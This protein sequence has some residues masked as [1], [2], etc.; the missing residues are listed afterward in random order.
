MTTKDVGKF[1]R[2]KLK[3]NP[4]LATQVSVEF[5]LAILAQQVY[6]LRIAAKLTQKELAQRIGVHRS[7]ISKIEDSD[8]D[9][10]VRLSTFMT[11]MVKLSDV[12]QKEINIVF[13][14]KEKE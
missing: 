3:E 8:I 9:G 13:V 1:I 12:F 14:D 7:W 4:E 6:N 11:V 10:S 2:Q 5:S